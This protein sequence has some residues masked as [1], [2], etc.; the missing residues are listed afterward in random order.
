MQK[1]K[2]SY[3]QELYTKEAKK[4]RFHRVATRRINKLLDTFRLI[5]NTSNT[6]LY[7]YTDSEVDKIFNTIENKIIEVKSKFR[8]SKDKNTFSF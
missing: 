3:R 5:G 6:N 2:S 7:L 4:A 8:K 1:N